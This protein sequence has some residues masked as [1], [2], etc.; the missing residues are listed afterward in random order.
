MVWVAL[1]FFRQLVRGDDLSPHFEEFYHFMHD[2][3]R[4][5]ALLSEVLLHPDTPADTAGTV[6]S[7]LTPLCKRRFYKKHEPHYDLG[8]LKQRVSEQVGRQR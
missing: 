3:D 4:L 7:E 1:E 5:A 8:P 6:L 2:F